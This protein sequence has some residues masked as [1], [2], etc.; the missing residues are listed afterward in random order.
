MNRNSS[1]QNGSVQL[2]ARKTQES[3]WVLRYR[4][5]GVKKAAF[6]G[7]LSE[8]P[9]KSAAERKA[10][11]LRVEINNKSRVTTFKDLADL[12]EEKELPERVSTRASIISNLRKLSDEFGKT[13]LM[14]MV[15]NP[16]LVEAWLHHLKTTPMPGRPAHSMS[17]KSKRHLLGLLSQMFD[18]AIAWGVLEMQRNPMEVVKIKGSAPKGKPKR[19]VL[20]GSHLSKMLADDL[21]PVREKVILVIGL[22]SGLRASEILGLRWESIDLKKATITVERSV[23][24]KYMDLPKTEDSYAEIPMHPAVQ[25]ALQLWKDEEPSINGWVFGS[26]ETGRPLWRDSI[27]KCYFAP[28]GKRLGVPDFGWHTL[29]HTY[30]NI[31]KKSGGLSLEMQKD[32]MRHS[33]ISMTIEYGTVPAM[34]A[35]KEANLAGTASLGS[36]EIVALTP[37]EKKPQLGVYPYQGRFQAR[38]SLGGLGKKYLGTFDTLDEAARAYDKAAKELRGKSNKA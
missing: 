4:E 34:E 24:G 38:I 3:Y 25:K 32:L 35:L 27:Q 12:F 8:L 29:R 14:D 30:R 5:N 11:N 21:L 28:L 9:M 17:P 22:F 13:S 36:G 18:R 10:L 6:L 33:D 37:R 20:D 31:L 23:V 2:I 19:G 1:Y 7:T 16:M 26:L 15:R